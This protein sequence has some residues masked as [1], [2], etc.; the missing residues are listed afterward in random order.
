[1]R[2]DDAAARKMKEETE[3]ERDMLGERQLGTMVT[4][5]KEQMDEAKDDEER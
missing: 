1:M 5:K 2:C 3:R 4:N